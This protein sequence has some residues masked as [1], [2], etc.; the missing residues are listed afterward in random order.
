MAGLKGSRSHRHTRLNRYTDSPSKAKRRR[1]FS[2]WWIIPASAL[3][4]ALLALALGNC[5]GNK[6]DD[7]PPE[8][9][10][11][12]DAPE[13]TEPIITETADVADIDAVFVGLE[14]ITDN[15]HHEVSK[16]IPEGTKAIS[17]SM[18]YSNGAPFYRSEVARSAGKECGELTLI[19]IFK[20][21]NENNIYV[22]VPFPSTAITLG[23]S[24]LWGVEAAYETAMIRELYEAGA[25][26]VIIRYSDYGITSGY[27]LTDEE[28][29]G[30]V[31]E[32]LSDLQRKLPGLNIGFMISAKDATDRSLTVI[33]DKLNSHADFLA[34]DMTAISDP[35]ALKD[36][37]NDALINILRY[38]MRVLIQRVDDESLSLAYQT[39]DSLGIKNRQVAVKNN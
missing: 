25:D 28:L 36:T 27:S 4:A 3:I 17:L 23:D 11:A 29:V 14:G 1:N 15:T 35:Q 30:R 32:Y 12:P 8:S 19:N 38:G 34:V 18:F 31:C 10:D 37:A 6:V 20:Y 5:L 24:L 2:L 26:E 33:I 21:A 9:S 13:T 22:S 7:L 16:Q 39:L